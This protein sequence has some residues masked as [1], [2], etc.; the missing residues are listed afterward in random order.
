MLGQETCGPGGFAYG[1]RSL[2]D[3]IEIVKDVRKHSKNAWI[4]NYTNPAAIVAYG[5]QREFPDDKR[6]L[7]ICDQPINLINSFAKLLD[8]PAESLEPTYFGSIIL[9][10]LPIFTTRMARICFPF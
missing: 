2:K 8:V 7:N 4:L 6:I 9:D 3:M 10:G 5:L 1:I